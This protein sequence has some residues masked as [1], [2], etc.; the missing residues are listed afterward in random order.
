MDECEYCTN[1]LLRLKLSDHPMLHLKTFELYIHSRN[2][3][4]QFVKLPFF[5]YPMDSTGIP[6]LHF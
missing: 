4:K 3:G 1:T 2:T 5:I 6:F